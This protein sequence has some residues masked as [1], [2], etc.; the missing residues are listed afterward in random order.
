M[1]NLSDIKN[2]LK[3]G[4]L[5]PSK[6]RGQNF[7]VN[8]QT[9]EAIV[10]NAGVTGD[11]T[12]VELGVGL[13]SLTLPLAAKAKHVI[14][15]EVDKGIITWH[16]EKN[17][18]PANVTLIHQD[19]LKSD[20][21]ELAKRAGGRLKIIANLPY[22]ISNPLI[23]K[24]LENREIME[25]AVLMLQKEVGQRLQANPGSKTY[26]VLSVLLGA[27][28]ATEIIM[29]VGPGQFHPRPKVDSVVTKI[30]FKPTPNRVKELPAHDFTLLKNLVNASFQQRRK[31][32]FNSLSSSNIPGTAKANLAV[33]LEKAGISPK[34][35]PERL[36]VEDFVRL[37]NTI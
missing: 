13:G 18:L 3:S 16:E 23:F 36:S 28:A 7:L 14:G 12:I 37:T 21:R 34:I 6:Q 30:T 17:I 5:A 33:V 4:Q 25:Y 31:T 27:Y 20:F 22:S 29:N 32:L 9:A 15:I 24:L 35:R 10:A 8:H 26:G 11:D 19:L 1:T 2:I